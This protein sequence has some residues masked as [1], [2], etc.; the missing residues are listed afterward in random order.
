M[1]FI[2]VRCAELPMIIMVAVKAA[3]TGVYPE[4]IEVKQKE[5][6]RGLQN[7]V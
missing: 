1:R 5:N 7:G 3:V 2:S 6:L 4:R